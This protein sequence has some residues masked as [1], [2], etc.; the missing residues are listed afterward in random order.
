MQARDLDKVCDILKRKTIHNKTL[1]INLTM[2]TAQMLLQRIKQLKA[3]K[4]RMSIEGQDVDFLVDT[5]PSVN[6]L[7]SKYAT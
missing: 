1:K 2:I 7:P 4:H 3:I 6:V 5:G